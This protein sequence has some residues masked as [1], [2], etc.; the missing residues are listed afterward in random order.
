M[1]AEYLSGRGAEPTGSLEDQAEGIAR[2]IAV[3]TAQ[4]RRLPV[5]PAHVA[6]LAAIVRLARAE[7]H[8]AAMRAVL[9]AWR[10]YTEN[11]DLDEL[12]RQLCDIAGPRVVAE[13]GEKDMTEAERVEG[14]IIG[15]LRAGG[16]WMDQKQIRKATG[17]PMSRVENFTLSMALENKIARRLV[18]DGHTPQFRALDPEATP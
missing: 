1:T 17:Q 16:G 11:D 10:L 2:R 8:A 12:V 7:G 9:D 18:N 14:L 13:N 4:T 6:R 15:A 5:D 3:E